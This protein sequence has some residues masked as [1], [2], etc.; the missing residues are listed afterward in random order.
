MHPEFASVFGQSPLLMEPT[1]LR[2]YLALAEKAT[3]EAIAEA[4]AAYGQR[5]T[6]PD[7]VGDVA[8]ISCCGPI[9]YK[10]TWF[11]MFF[12]GSSIMEMQAQ[13]RT[14]LAD[15]AVRVIA[16]RWDS[17]GGTVEMVP[18]FGDELFAARGTKPIVSVADTMIASACAWLAFQTDTIYVSV[19]SMIGAVGVFVNHT[20]ISAMLEKDG[21]KV[22]QIAYGDHKLDGTQ[23]A[24]LSDSAR[25]IFQAYVDELGGEF[26][27]ACAR[28]RGVSKKVVADTFGQGQVFRGKKAIALGMA[29]KMGTFGQVIGKLTKGR[30]S[31]ASARAA[32]AMPAPAATSTSEVP[33]A[34]AGRTHKTGAGSRQDDGCNACSEACP[35]DQDECPD[36]C[37]T[38]DDDCPCRQ[39]DAEAKTARL[40]AEAADRDAVAIAI[41]LGDE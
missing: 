6:G 31:G 22:T 1:K 15:P 26:D 29:D 27:A 40:A 3:P 12:G 39:E 30:S 21:V 35:C 9:T 25:E 2:E 14:A 11:S 32:A 23:F 37:T 19:S 24:P 4:V 5:P 38:C 8:V 16:F 17:P 10:P 36:D 13:F 33:V 20:D 18:E 7:M 28:G 41:A 34:I